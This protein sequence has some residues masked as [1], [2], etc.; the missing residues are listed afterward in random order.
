MRNRTLWLASALLA[1]LAVGATVTA[2]DDPKDKK[3]APPG[4]A[5]EPGDRKDGFR[6][7]GKARG[8]SVDQIVERIMAF[9]KN[10]DGKVTKDELPERMQDLIAQGDTNKDGALDKDEV[11]KLATKIANEGPRGLGA[12][13]RFGGRGGPGDGFRGGRGGVEGALADLKLSDKK[14]ETAEAAVKAY[15]ENVRK[16]TDLARA[17]LLLKMKDVLSDEE[18]KK[19]KEALDR[20]PGPPPRRRAR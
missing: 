4:K 18:Y 9:D 10:K 2:A 7:K 19:F 17:D 15:Q 8:V 20:P 1:A 16:L 13:G 12:L 3:E 5:G 14:K 11:K 6:G